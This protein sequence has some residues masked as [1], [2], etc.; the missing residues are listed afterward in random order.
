MYRLQL[1][2][3]HG[4]GL[5]VCATLEDGAVLESYLAHFVAVRVT[6]SN[7]SIMLRLAAAVMPGK[8]HQPQNTCESQK[9][10]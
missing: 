7:P 8:Q 2:Q 5:E 9:P 3:L 6:A 1:A 4:E 10:F